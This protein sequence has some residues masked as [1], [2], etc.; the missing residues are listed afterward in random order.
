MA[1]PQPA[2]AKKKIKVKGTPHFNP[3][4]SFTPQKKM[5]PAPMQGL[6][7]IIFNNTGTAKAASTFNLNVK[8]ISKHVANCLKFV[9]P[10]AALAIRELKDPI[11]TFPDKLTDPSNLVKT[12]KWQRK[13][14][15]AHDQQKWWDKNTQKIYNLEMQH[16]TPE[17]KTKLLTMD[18]WEATSAAQDGI[19]LLKVIRD[20]C[21]KKDGGTNATTILDLVHMDKE[22]FLVHQGPTKPLL[23][24][25]SKFKSAIDVVKSS[26]GTPWPH[27]A[28]TKIIFNKIYASSPTFALAKASNLSNYQALV[29]EVQ[30]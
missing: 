15:H 5:F 29:T 19:G 3:R 30:H 17:M 1:T 14:N 18:S 20:I 8:A 28:A 9:G 27:P 6:K 12:T 4:H 2:N 21:H 22:M 16:S 26:N 7:H 13:Y 10:L 11:I 25:L 23:S 24:Y